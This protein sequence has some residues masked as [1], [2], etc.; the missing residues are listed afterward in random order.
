MAVF[1][2]VCAV[3]VLVIAS[4]GGILSLI[5]IALGFGSWL[6]FVATTI[7][8]GWLAVYGAVL[9]FRGATSP[10]ADVLARDDVEQPVG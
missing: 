6:E 9:A 5:G 2:R 4:A 1:S 7:A 10:V 8:I 3:A